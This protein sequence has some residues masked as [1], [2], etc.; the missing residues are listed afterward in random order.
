MDLPQCP[1]LHPCR[2]RRVGA[3]GSG[4]GLW[5]GRTVL[6]SHRISSI[7]YLDYRS[8]PEKHVF[9]PGSMS[10]TREH[11]T[12][13]APGHPPCTHSPWSSFSLPVPRPGPD[14]FLDFPH[15][16]TD[17]TP[18]ASLP[19]DFFVPAN[20]AETRRTKNSGVVC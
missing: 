13:S 10:V 5:D 14:P 2:G 9:C 17:G 6:P 11:T 20:D 15:D 3:D 19:G 8:R 12:E 4:R 18:S 16:L 1:S 7:L